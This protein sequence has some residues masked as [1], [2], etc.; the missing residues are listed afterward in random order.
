MIETTCAAC[1]SAFQARR[2]TARFCSDACRQ[3]AHRVGPPRPP[4][5]PQP[6][7]ALLT[8]LADKARAA[9][10]ANDPDIARAEIAQV[11]VAL[12]RLARWGGMTRWC[13]IAKAAEQQRAE[14][15]QQWQAEHRMSV[16]NAGFRR[17]GQAAEQWPDGCRCLA[18]A[19]RAARSRLALHDL[20]QEERIVPGRITFPCRKS[21]QLGGKWRQVSS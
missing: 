13:G 11:V 2:S 15:Q 20:R 10:A 14:R 17:A 3:R 8:F 6:P 5:E 16:K 19:T 1:G 18:S 12:E 21:L 7:S 4:P 9:L